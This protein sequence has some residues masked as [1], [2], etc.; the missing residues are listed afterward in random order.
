MTQRKPDAPRRVVTVRDAG[1]R[2]PRPGRRRQH[3]QDAAL[4]G[5]IILAAD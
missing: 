2:G 3:G 1:G 4:V 5:G